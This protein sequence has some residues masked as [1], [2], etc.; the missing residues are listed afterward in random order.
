M[1]GTNSNG[2]SENG[3]E[4]HLGL[5]ISAVKPLFDTVVQGKL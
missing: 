5:Q 4:M 3:S 1:D 2:R